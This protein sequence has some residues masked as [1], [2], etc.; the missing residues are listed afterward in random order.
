MKGIE[1]L[2]EG[3]PLLNKLIATEEVF[4]VNPNMEKYE[5]A[6][7]DSP[8]SEENVK[9]A[10]ER[11]KRFASYIAKVF[12][13]TKETK[14]IIE[15]PLLKIPSMKQALEKNYEQPIL[16]ELLLK[17]D[18]HLPISGSIK[19]RGGIYEV[20]KHAEQLALQHGM[21]T[22]EDDYSILDSDTCR[23]FFAKYSIAVGST[24]NLGLSI[25]IMS[26]KLGFNVTV[27][28]SAD[29]KQ[30][31][32]DLLRSKGVNVIE[33]EADYS[34]AV[35]EGRRQADADPSCY[36][37]DDEN[38]HDLFL[39]YAVAASRL[40]K[41]LD[42][43]EIVVDEEHPLFVYLPC[44]VGGGPGGVAFGLKLLYKDNVHCFFAEPTHS[45]CM[46][47]GLMTG[48]HD[49]I[50]VQ[51]IGIDN[52][53]DADGLAVGRPSGFVGKTIE[54]FLSGNY[55]VSDEELYRLLKELAD[56][57]KIYLEPSA[58]AG[59]I[60]PVKVCKEDAY[61]QEQQL[62]KEMKKGTHIVWGTGGSM[63]PEDVM[64][65]YY[66]TGEALMYK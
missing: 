3:Y 40:Q 6:I 14:G 5:T 50:A 41:Q 52:V 44:G 17:C 49:K 62:M 19:A 53:T 30:W 60:G 38:S 57:E 55:T 25:G 34:K 7:K 4:W 13:E 64:D 46:L 63:V 65:G 1:K 20:L 33:Y 12:P 36:F 56:T 47:L 39:G 61:L 21:L 51:D 23:E 10:E 48:L 26:A 54:P 22:E 29:A 24:G 59:M 9:D 32:K 15:S 37:V 35:E 16:G 42:E 31:K 18:S 43:L 11:L 27:H 28:M 66:K 2:K 8:L 45:P 58:L